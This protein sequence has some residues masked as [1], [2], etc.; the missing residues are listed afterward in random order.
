MRLTVLPVTEPASPLGAVG[1]VVSA[2]TVADASFETGPMLP[3]AS[4]AVTL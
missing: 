4:S 3:A 1:A 2:L